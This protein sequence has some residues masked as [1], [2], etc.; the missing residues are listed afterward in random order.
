MF[1]VIYGKKILFYYKNELITS[2]NFSKVGLVIRKLNKEEDNP[3]LKAKK[4][5]GD[6]YEII[7]K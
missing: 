1:L 5:K 2:I 6:Y 4:A 7:Y 3:K